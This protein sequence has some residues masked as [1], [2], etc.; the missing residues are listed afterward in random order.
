MVGVD[1]VE[2]NVADSVVLEAG[3]QAEE[4]TGLG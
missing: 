4:S 3:D 1:L 2:R